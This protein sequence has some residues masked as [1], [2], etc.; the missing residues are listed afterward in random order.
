MATCTKCG[1]SG[2]GLLEVKNGKCPTCRK[3]E[4]QAEL[5]KTDEQR[6]REK[7][8]KDTALQQ[9]KRL[10]ITTETTLNQDVER[11][12]VVASEVVLGMNLFKDAL[13]NIRDIFGGRSGV[14]QKTLKDARELAFSEIRLQA[15]E[16]GADA[17][18]AV[19][20]D[21]HSMSTG[22]SVNMMIVSVSG[23]AVKREQA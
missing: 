18:I 16:L 2:F 8:A 21:Y 11:L 1:K 15:A 10:T 20:I 7:V 3:A 22:S 4:E 23:T 17:V 14:V 13:A 6:A 12:G 19:D 9:A 5:S